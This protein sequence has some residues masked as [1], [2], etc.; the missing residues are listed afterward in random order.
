MRYKAEEVNHVFFNEIKRYAPKPGVDEVCKEVIL[1]LY[2][3]DFA[4]KGDGRREVLDK[5][6]ALT[7]RQKNAM[8]LLLKGDLDE[9]EY[10][11]IKLDCEAKINALEAKLSDFSI[12]NINIADDLDKLRSP[13]RF[14]VADS[15]RYFS[16]IPYTLYLYNYQLT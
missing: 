14:D 1:D 16:I 11:E 6:D 4:S 2:N 13:E 10:K 12:K 8:E 9:I 7:K 15:S 5:I 3:S